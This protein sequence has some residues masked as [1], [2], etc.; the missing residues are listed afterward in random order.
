MTRALELHA[1]CGGRWVGPVPGEGAAQD[2]CGNCGQERPHERGAVTR[3]S[4]I[5]RAVRV[6]DEVECEAFL[7]LSIAP[8][9]LRE[10]ADA[11][12][13][14][15]TALYVEAYRESPGRM[16]GHPRANAYRSVADDIMNA[17]LV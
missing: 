10:R 17:R 12:V 15:R 5:K 1:R 7:Y 6:P 16:V 8:V 3:G 14:R 2:V 11:E 13:E 9:H 4:E